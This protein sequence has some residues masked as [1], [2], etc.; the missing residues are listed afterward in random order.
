MPTRVTPT[1]PAP[2]IGGLEPDAVTRALIA[3]YLEPHGYRVQLAPDLPAAL[4][5]LSEGPPA[6]FLCSQFGL[7]RAAP[8]ERQR[9]RE[10]L[11][12]VPVACLLEPGA[13]PGIVRGWPTVRVHLTKPLQA[14]ALLSALESPDAA[15]AKLVRVRPRPAGAAGTEGSERAEDVLEGFTALIS[16]MEMDPAMVRDLARSFLERAPLYL[17]DIASGLSEG[18]LTQ[19]DRAAHTMKGMCG[20][21]RFRALMELSDRLRVAARAGDTAG[22]EPTVARLRA[23]LASVSDAVRR[24]WME[25][26]PGG[27]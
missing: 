3:L 27:R 23:A 21:L 13:A 4:R 17:E 10:A 25:G 9:L 16:E 11:G 15:L 20:N 26:S 19:V 12:T 22:L 7:E 18:N 14:D 6:L 2:L 1:Q 5:G 24:R 8:E